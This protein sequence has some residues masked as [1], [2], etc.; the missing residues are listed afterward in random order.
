[1]NP[2]FHGLC[3]YGVMSPNSVVLR[4]APSHASRPSARTSATAIAAER[5]SSKRA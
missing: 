1:M 5:K 3:R 2:A 4:L